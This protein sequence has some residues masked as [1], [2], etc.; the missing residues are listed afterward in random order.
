MGYRWDHCSLE[1]ADFV[2]YLDH[3]CKYF[4]A[5]QL[6]SN[7]ARTLENLFH[8][9]ENRYKSHIEKISVNEEKNRYL[10]T[11]TSLE[12]GSL[13]FG[14]NDYSA[15]QLYH[16]ALNE[17]DRSV[18]E[19]ETGFHV[20]ESYLQTQFS[21]NQTSPEVN[22]KLPSISSGQKQMNEIK[23]Q[24]NTNPLSVSLELSPKQFFNCEMDQYPYTNPN[25]LSAEYGQMQYNMPEM[26]PELY[27]Y[28]PFMSS[29]YS[30]L[31]FSSYETNQHLDTNQR[32]VPP[33]YNEIEFKPRVENQKF[34]SSFKISE[35]SQ[36]ELGRHERNPQFRTN[37]STFSSEYSQMKY[38]S[39]EMN[40]QFGTNKRIVSPGYIQMEN[41]SKDKDPQFN[42]NP[43][44]VTNENENQPLG[45]RISSQQ[46]IRVNELDLKPPQNFK[47]NELNLDPGGNFVNGG[48]KYANT[49]PFQQMHANISSLTQNELQGE[50]FHYKTSLFNWSFKQ[51]SN[52]DSKET[53]KQC[54]NSKRSVSVKGNQIGCN[55]YHKNKFGYCLA[56]EK[57]DTLNPGR[58]S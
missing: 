16:E 21:A 51:P 49:N 38:H 32:I 50:T 47:S 48:T 56:E 37:Q 10:M 41:C 28:Q 31:E 34:H 20:F 52:V 42:A 18:R 45:E 11:D 36:M 4:N 55:I 3:E 1:F 46:L 17:R 8:T 25:S 54:D 53:A 19:R 23:A 44:I 58:H 33:H 2:E 5:T 15:N 24:I 43:R 30:P 9:C 12:D 39:K 35:H 57:L 7:E 29:E 27:R 14:S 22:F 13:H 40:P 6:T 26:N